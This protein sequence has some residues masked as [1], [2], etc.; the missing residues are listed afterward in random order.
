MSGANSSLNR[1]KSKDIAQFQLDA[2]TRQK[3]RGLGLHLMSG[4]IMLRAG[5]G[6]LKYV[7]HD[8]VFA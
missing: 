4:T 3:L 1:A 2:E 7:S 8:V 5:L 6:E